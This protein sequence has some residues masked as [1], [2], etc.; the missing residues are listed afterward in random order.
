MFGSHFSLRSRGEVLRLTWLP[1]KN[2][3]CPK[4]YRRSGFFATTQLQA[5][6]Q[7]HVSID[8]HHK[9]QGHHQRWHQTTLRSHVTLYCGRF[10]SSMQSSTATAAGVFVNDAKLWN[11]CQVH[12]YIQNKSE[13]SPHQPLLV[14]LDTGRPF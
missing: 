14:P 5:S 11:T 4:W 10:Q 2:V 6:H 13:E 7:L 3:V 12:A 8:H 1:L 9:Q